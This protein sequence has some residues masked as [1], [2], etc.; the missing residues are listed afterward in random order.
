MI[1]KTRSIHKNLFS[2]HFGEQQKTDS[3]ML[4]QVA[5]QFALL[6][7]IILMFD[8]FLDLLMGCLDLIIGLFYVG[9]D[10]VE[11]FFESILENTVNIGHR[12]SDIIIVN[13]GLIIGLYVLYRAIFAIPRL[14]R[15]GVRKC[16]AAWLLKKRHRTAHWRRMTPVLKIKLIGAYMCATSGLLFLVTL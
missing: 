5:M 9:M 7:F 10:S 8:S 3:Q 1:E 12:Q 14:Y 11:Y 13:G 4:R 16:K 6:C 15:K 2:Q